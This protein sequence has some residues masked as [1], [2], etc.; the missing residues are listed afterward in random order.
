MKLVKVELEE[1]MVVFSVS[2]RFR[3]FCNKI[4]AE[5]TCNKKMQDAH[6]RYSFGKMPSAPLKTLVK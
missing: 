3:Y 1:I 5:K 4:I 2:V 6:P